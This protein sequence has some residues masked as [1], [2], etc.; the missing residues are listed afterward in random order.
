MEQLKFY[1]YPSCTSCRRTKS[2]LK[3]QGVEFNEQH[4]FRETPSIDELR[5][6]LTLTTQ[7]IDEI[8]AK[9]SKEFKAL[10]ID[11]EDL[12]MNEF[13]N[14]VTEKPK[15]L[16]RPILTNGEKIVVGYDVEGL[17]GITNKKMEYTEKIS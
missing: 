6:I 2:W 12:T 4:L 17:R 7:G 8:L 16:R 9:R 14:L 15:L 13:L 1:T 10:D 5:N 3:S 11:I